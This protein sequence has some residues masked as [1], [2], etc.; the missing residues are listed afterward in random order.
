MTS[1]QII[2]G[3]AAPKNTPEFLDGVIEEMGFPVQRVQTDR[4]S[5]FF[6]YKVQERLMNYGIK[7]RPIRPASPH[8]NGKVE[9][10][11]KSDKIEFYA[12]LKLRI[13][14]IDCRSGNTTTIG[15]D[16]TER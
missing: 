13:S 4:G 2:R 8:L 12:I 16:R 1:A 11:Q 3:T 9:R 14:K 15:G 6:A 10:S 7:F 5:E